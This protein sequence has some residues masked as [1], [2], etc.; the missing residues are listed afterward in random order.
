[1]ASTITSSLSQESPDLEP[2]IFAT[3]QTAET[4]CLLGGK[5]DSCQ[6]QHQR[7]CPARLGT[8][9]IVLNG[10]PGKSGGDGAGDKRALITRGKDPPYRQTGKETLM[11]GR[12]SFTY[13]YTNIVKFLELCIGPLFSE[14]IGFLR[15]SG[16]EEIG[17]GI[18]HGRPCCENDGK[19]FSSLSNEPDYNPAGTEKIRMTLPPL[20]ELLH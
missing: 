4:D 11:K 1:M 10:V 19:C 13:T 20:R 14:F 8:P 12:L 2:S 3:A 17:D 5:A 15:I 18:V 16:V 9:W 7:A 6:G